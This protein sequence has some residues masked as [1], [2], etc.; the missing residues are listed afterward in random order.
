MKSLLITSNKAFEAEED[1]EWVKKKQFIRSSPRLDTNFVRKIEYKL[2]KDS[3]IGQRNF[4][5][6]D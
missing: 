1:E 2:N 6:S 4:R 3:Q 5:A